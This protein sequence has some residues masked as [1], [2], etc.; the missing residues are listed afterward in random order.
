[1]GNIEC[2]ILDSINCSRCGFKDKTATNEV[3]LIRHFNEVRNQDVLKLGNHNKE[4][5]KDGNILSH[6]PKRSEGHKGWG[7]AYSAEALPGT[8]TSIVYIPVRYTDNG[9][10]FVMLGVG[11]PENHD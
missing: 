4:C 3:N 8:P 5:K 7:Y 11:N 1:M 9:Q 10:G 6:M 2:Q